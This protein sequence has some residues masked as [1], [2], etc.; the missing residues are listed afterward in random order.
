MQ[1]LIL[2]ICLALPC[3][4]A[5]M[6]VPN[7]S[8][9]QAAGDGALGWS[10][11]SRTKTGSALRTADEHHSL[12]HSMCIRHDGDR[13][14]AFS[15]SHRF[16][17]TPGQ[18]FTISAWARVKKGSAQLALVALRK[19]KTLAWDVGSATRHADDGTDWANITAYAEAPT[20]CDHVYVRFIGD[21]HTL[22][23]LDDVAIAPA[24]RRKPKP[25]PQIQ[26]YATTRI[27]ERL[28]RG[29]VA[30]PT[31]GHAVY[32]G[33][34]LLKNDPRDI[35]FNVYR[36]IGKSK[37]V[38][39]NKEPLR[40]TTD[41]IDASPP[42]GAASRYVV[43]PILAG[44][45][46]EPSDTATA[47]PTDAPLPYIAHKFDGG[48][49]FQKAGIADLDGDGRLDYVLKQPGD[50][51]DPY[52]K[53]WK[54]SPDTYTLEAYGHDGR[55]LWRHDL[56]WAIERGIWY[57]PYVVYDLDGDGKAEVAVKTGEGDPRDPDGRVKSGAEH[58]TLLDGLTGKP[59]TR[60]DWVPRSLFRGARAYNYAS[61]NQLGIAYLDGKTPC[62]LVARGTYNLMIVDAY[63]FHD[64]R[65]RKLWQWSNRNAPRNQWG[66][67]AHWMHCADVDGDG[68][69]E[70][71]LGSVVLDDTGA[72]LWSTGYG[73][74]DHLYL[75][76]IDPARPGLEVYYGIETRRQSNAMCLVDA[77]TGTLLWG[78]DQP[79]T[80]IHSS[81]LCSDI[82]PA[83]AGA[84]CYSG[85]RDFKDK[86]WLRNAR[87]KVLATAD[88]GGLAPRPLHWDATPQRAIFRR[89]KIEKHG[90]ATL[91]P[92][93]EGR[94]VAVADILG[95]WREELIVSVP[96]EMRIYTTA[97]PATD[98]RPCLM[99]DP[100]Y[101]LDVAH[102]AMGYTQVPM[103]SI[104]LG[105]TQTW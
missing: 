26:A 71:V 75:G 21:G 70:V 10:W 25:K 35:A 31:A 38:C 63:E 19:G 80:H 30:R 104:D 29:I 95:D 13:D 49:T 44:R 28:R 17:A 7:P 69:D 91:V 37:A 53:Y 20:D 74:P 54:K 33:W 82:D 60:A 32:V 81:G 18:A 40:K 92:K 97:L 2:L 87:G 11:W 89:G 5:D 59:R 47:T 34:R 1:R 72:V 56:G 51:I 3:L 88:L 50:N 43:L 77:K 83:H 65:L 9:E 46:G 8:F 36:Q 45:E 66:Q 98:R 61:R 57:S 23:W 14:W 39:L 4:A 85:E 103:L 62:L 52:E 12:G 6:H 84:E 41:F 48:H 58:I 73:H 76:D 96:G 105:T 94:F 78:H 100:L 22:A 99:Q 27:V 15:S 55:L 16:P 93:V 86:R 90:G 68:R 101:R 79:T 102:A 67:G 64:N 24:E 42:R